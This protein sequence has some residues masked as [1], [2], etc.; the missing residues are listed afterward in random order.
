MPEGRRFWFFRVFSGVLILSV[1]GN[2]HLS[3][4]F[5][6]DMMSFHDWRLIPVDEIVWLYLFKFKQCL[7]HRSGTLWDVLRAPFT[8]PPLPLPCGQLI[9]KV[10][11]VYSNFASMSAFFGLIISKSKKST[12]IHSNQYNIY[13]LLNVKTAWPLLTTNCTKVP[14][15]DKGSALFSCAPL[16]LLKIYIWKV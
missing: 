8:R 13:Q 9:D 5:L 10:L 3:L 16:K 2:K 14:L 4:K 12:F 6:L 11:T 15:K 7:K 1:F